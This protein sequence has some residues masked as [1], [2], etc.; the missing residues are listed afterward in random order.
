MKLKRLK[1]NPNL[2]IG[3]SIAYEHGKQ[4]QLEADQRVLDMQEGYMEQAKQ[5]VIRE[6][7]EETEKAM[8]N[9]G[10]V[11][12]FHTGLV[13]SYDDWQELKKKRGVE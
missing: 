6:F 5:A 8:F 7:I 9:L 1:D 11:S 3:C 2:L 12:S 4:A 10:V 13:I